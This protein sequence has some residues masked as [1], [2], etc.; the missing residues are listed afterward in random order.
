M[1]CADTQAMTTPVANPATGDRSGPSPA[2]SHR[3]VFGGISSAAKARESIAHRS[4][5]R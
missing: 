1:V 2:H 3:A 5:T 4:H